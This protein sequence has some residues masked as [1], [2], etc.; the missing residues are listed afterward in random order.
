[1]AEAGRAQQGGESFGRA[2][3]MTA[4]PGLRRATPMGTGTGNLRSGGER[5]TASRGRHMARDHGAASGG[6]GEQ[7]NPNLALIPCEGEMSNSVLQWGKGQMYKVSFT[8]RFL[9]KGKNR[10]LCIHLS[11]G[12]CSSGELVKDGCG[13]KCYGA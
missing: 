6:S 7:A 1:M 3:Q 4:D 11:R 8:M 5:R 10:K 9:Y 2:R 13:T 12:I